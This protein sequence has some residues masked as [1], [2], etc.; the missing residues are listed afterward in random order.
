M[1]TAEVVGDVERWLAGVHG[2]VHATQGNLGEDGVDG[3]EFQLC[4]RK[5]HS[6]DIP[7]DV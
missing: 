4:W 1:G 2:G 7:H 5:I 3:G 6:R